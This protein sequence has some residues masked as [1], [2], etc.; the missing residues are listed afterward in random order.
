MPEWRDHLRPR[1]AR[2][3]L[4]PARETEIVDELSQ[5]LDDRYEELRAGGVDDADAR[6][7]AIAE[8]REPDALARQM[9][10]L[11]QAHVP[12]PVTPGAPN[13][14]AAGAIWQDL[15]YAVRMLR[16]QPGFTAA[17]VLTL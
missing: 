3:R 6:R 14:F 5:H 17:A 7:M 11:R 8:L 4:D 2:L 16:K 13:R 10:S 12:P 1:L 9:R 15:R